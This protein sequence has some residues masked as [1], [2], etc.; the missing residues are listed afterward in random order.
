MSRS[1]V[2]DRLRIR[3][4]RA[5]GEVTMR[6]LRRASCT[7]LIAST[8]VGCGKGTA[9]VSET[10]SLLTIH[11]ADTGPSAATGAVSSV[12]PPLSALPLAQEC[13]L[14]GDPR[15]SITGEEEGAGAGLCLSRHDA[16]AALKL[17]ASTIVRTCNGPLP[18]SSG[19]LEVVFN[20]DG[21]VAYATLPEEP[22]RTSP[23]R[24]CI[25]T[26]ARNMRIRP[27]IGRSGTYA[28]RFHY[29]HFT[30]AGS[31]AGGSVFDA[32]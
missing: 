32:R 6:M 30:D 19:Q 28:V 3:P 14:V 9:A 27:F 12:Q 23:V 18:G 29:P 15:G 11:E 2:L 4:L 13:P 31:S 5:V 21:S 25:E 26:V 16:F 1:L 24:G 22:W 20:N 7:L 8:F 10:P 17:A